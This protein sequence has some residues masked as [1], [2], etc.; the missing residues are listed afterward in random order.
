MTLPWIQEDGTDRDRIVRYEESHDI[1]RLIFHP[2]S[3]AV[4]ISILLKVL[5]SMKGHVCLVNPNA[6]KMIRGGGW[7]GCC[8]TNVR[9][10]FQ[11]AL[12]AIMKYYL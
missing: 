10:D 11:R 4:S 2:L 9:Q 6:M 12:L 5:I 3:T 7:C 8:E 1:P